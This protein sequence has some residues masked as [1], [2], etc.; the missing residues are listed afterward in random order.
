[1]SWDPL[2]PQVSLFVL[3]YL[4]V[5]GAWWSWVLATCDD[6]NPISICFELSTEWYHLNFL[7][8]L[9]RTLMEEVIIHKFLGGCGKL[10]GSGVT[11]KF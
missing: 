2:G 8:Y 10:G 11:L 3:G 4:G 1:M 7:H 9:H 6:L 5:L